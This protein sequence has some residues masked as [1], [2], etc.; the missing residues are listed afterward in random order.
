ML[1]KLKIFDKFRSKISLECCKSRIQF[2]RIR[3]KEFRSKIHQEFLPVLKIVS[4]C[5][6]SNQFKIQFKECSQTTST[7][8]ACTRLKTWTKTRL[9]SS[10][11][12]NSTLL[13][14]QS[15]KLNKTSLCRFTRFRNTATQTATQINLEFHKIRFPLSLL[16]WKDSPFL[17]KLSS[18]SFNLLPI[19]T[20]LFTDLM[21]RR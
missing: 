9:S 14:V 1:E 13:S 6:S 8:V 7:W 21:L 20:R 12:E 17:K 18:L 19:F 4:K 3:S 2:A 11:M 5:S 16:L 10:V 15:F